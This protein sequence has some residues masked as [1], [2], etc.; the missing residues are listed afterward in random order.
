MPT[1]RFL[2]TETNEE[3]DLFMSMTELDNYIRENNNVKQLLTT[4]TPTCDPTRV[5]VTT[6]PD[7]NFRDVLKNIKSKFHKSTINT[8]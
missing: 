5:G 7:S 3:Y 4:P 2:N 1:Y 8:Y 6:K